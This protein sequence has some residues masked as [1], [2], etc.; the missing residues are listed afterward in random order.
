MKQLFLIFFASFLFINCGNS[1]EI[2]TISTL[3]LKDLL[4][5]DKVQIV[6]VRTKNEI[7]Y[8][9]IESS[10]FIDF[11]DNNFTEKA[12]NKLDKNKP[13][14]L[15]CRSGNRSGNAT[16]LLQGKGYEVY[17][18]LGGYNQWKKENKK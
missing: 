7:K 14:Y 3:E 2:K 8:G 4:S 6:D 10:I 17:N 5:K 12:V 11:F 1:Q 16:K 9:F 18:V 15:Y 13:V